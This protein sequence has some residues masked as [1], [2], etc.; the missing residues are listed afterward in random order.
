ML[1]TLKTSTSLPILM[2][3]EQVHSP[4][5]SWNDFNPLLDLSGEKLARNISSIQAL[6]NVQWYIQNFLRE[7]KAVSHKNYPWQTWQFRQQWLSWH[8]FSLE[9]NKC[10]NL[11]SSFQS[12]L[13]PPPIILIWPSKCIMRYNLHW[14]RQRENG[15]RWEC[16]WKTKNMHE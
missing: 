13:I 8:R 16:K 4:Q 6:A 10:V 11:W 1:S 9:E 12:N 5:T 7:N 2:Q 15:G 3:Q 14:I